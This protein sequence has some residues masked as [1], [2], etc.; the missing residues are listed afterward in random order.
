MSVLYSASDMGA[1]RDAL[2]C[3]G[4][5]LAEADKPGESAAAAVDDD[6]NA[7]DDEAPEEDA[8]AEPVLQ[9]QP[10]A[11][12]SPRKLVPSSFAFVGEPVKTAGGRS[13]YM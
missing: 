4:A 7:E 12:L 13:F 8:L 9:P 6:V 11:K 5:E 2:I 10:A 3:A 1:A